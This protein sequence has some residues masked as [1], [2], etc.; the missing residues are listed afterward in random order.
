MPQGPI[1]TGTVTFL[2]TD[3][4]GS[5][6]LW[7]S[8]PEEMREVLARHDTLVREAIER[9][10]GFIFK[11]LGDAF[12][13][14]FATAPDALNAAVAAQRAI[15][16][17]Q[18][19]ESTP[20]RVR[21]AL[22]TGAVEGR[23]DDY[24]GPAV[25]RVA[26]LL[27]TG[28]GGQTL[29]SQTTYDLVQ[30]HLEPNV[31][32]RDLGAHQLKDLARPEQIYQVTHPEFPVDFPA[33]RSL[34]THPNNLP[35]QVS[36]FVGREKETSDVQAL[37]R[38][39]RLVSL[40]GAGGTGKT[41]LG[42]Q[43]AANALELFPD[44]V[45]L[46]E[47]A[48]LNDPA[49]VPEAVAM[50]FGLPDDP[51]KPVLEWVTEHLQDKRL[52][53]VLDNCEHLIEACAVLVD[54]LLRRC[55]DI[56]VLATSR[57]GLGIGGETA[58]RVPSLSLPDPK[59]RHTLESLSHF[60]SVRLFIDRATQADTG[61]TVTNENAPA[62][63]SICH[64][65]DGIPLA[66]E[67]A[68]AR[69]RTLSV[70]EINNKLDHRFRLLVSGNRTALPRQQTLRSLIDWSYDLLS[71]DEKVMLQRLSVFSGGFTLESAER[72]CAGDPV[73]ESGVLDL[74]TSL[75]N[76]SLLVTDQLGATTRY[77]L[78]ET[79]RQYAVDRLA[80]SGYWETAHDRHLQHFLEIANQA[81]E[82]AQTTEAPQMW[83]H[84]EA[85]YDNMRAA[86]EWAG[87]DS[88]RKDSELWIAHGLWGFWSTRGRATEG[89][90][91]LQ[92]ALEGSEHASKRARACAMRS[93]GTLAWAQ[94]DL[95][96]AREIT[97]QSLILFRELDDRA[98][99]ARSL[100]VL[101]NVACDQ[102]NHADARAY[103]QESLAIR[104]EIGDQ[105]GISQSLVNLGNAASCEG[106]LE[107]ALKYY[108]D[109]TVIALEAARF[110]GAANGLYNYAYCL[111]LLGD[112][113]GSRAYQ[114][115][116]FSHAE[117]VGDRRSMAISHYGLG[118][119]DFEEGRYADAR[120]HYK[121][122]LRLMHEFGD[123]LRLCDCLDA[124]A[125]LAARE[126]S[127]VEAAR[128]WGA[129]DRLRR[130][131]AAPR[132]PHEQI[133]H[134]RQMAEARAALSDEAFDREWRVGER[135]SIEAVIEAALAGG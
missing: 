22:H 28:H 10:H 32:L 116:C 94:T 41:R 109:G 24:F 93:Q 1:P 68:A 13:V 127:G 114:T 90:Q 52:L 36:T 60:E 83:A 57:E 111:F 54:V 74:L 69:L 45:W 73:E 132:I 100:N 88:S 34:S 117:M 42:I 82:S 119:I 61:F 46:V 104:R 62:L 95:N 16:S 2:F 120:A 47:L 58:Y 31:G 6:R 79:V 4:E 101:G 51:S 9:Y 19:S 80:E 25:N 102:G 75:A 133:R 33:I 15:Q 121:N 72:V 135:L 124:L 43:V 66:I 63:A 44:G 99:I 27:S 39:Q 123:R 30:D 81:A 14:A 7:E 91:R 98:E 96:V 106:D 56:V 108:W 21:M 38:T 126:G 107:T 12:Y 67:L 55:S 103:Y 20:I 23:D 77:R 17:E 84:V 35:Q 18:W 40:L 118:L 49:V 134:D 65:L 53:I 128:T 3:I 105:A 71:D 115:Q 97:G 113:E 5:T 130:E 85:N 26:R 37:L 92:R 70:E 122:G 87:S 8:H 112:L 59:E 48:P 86:M 50:T 11:T 131:I 129:E 76:K 78:L 125:A 29:V 89:R 64:R 110:R